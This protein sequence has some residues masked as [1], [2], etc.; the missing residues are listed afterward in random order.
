MPVFG[1]AWV[2]RGS[3][4]ARATSRSSSVPPPLSELLPL[5]FCPLQVAS[6]G[7]EEALQED[8]MRRLYFTPFAL[9]RCG[10]Y[11]ERIQPFLRHFKHEK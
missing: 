3:P 2:G 11:A 5:P 6:L 9:L 8:L 7:P 4:Q 1:A 10:R